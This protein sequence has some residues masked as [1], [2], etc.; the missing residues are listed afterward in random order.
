MGF[1]ALLEL[2]MLSSH[3]PTESPLKKRRKFNVSLPDDA[4]V[5]IPPSTRSSGAKVSMANLPQEYE[6]VRLV[7]D[8]LNPHET[9]DA[10]TP[11]CEWDGVGCSQGDVVT[12]IRWTGRDL[13]GSLHLSHFM[14]TM[15]RFNV[16]RNALTGE[17][18]LLDLPSSL[19]YLCLSENRFVGALD[20]TSLPQKLAELDIY[21]NSFTEG[22]CL[23]RL[24]PALEGLYLSSNNL[25]GSV[26]LTSLPQSMKQLGLRDNLL[27]GEISLSQLPQNLLGLSLRNNDFCGVVDFRRLPFTLRWLDVSDNERITGEIAPSRYLN[28]Q[29]SVANTGVHVVVE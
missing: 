14:Q 19:R 5:Q 7:R 17:I 13:H 9:W 1:L 29:F 6:L 27:S 3:D 4:T 11:A 8:I 25:T 20:L 2:K 12:R 23:T 21:D 28:L 15:K 18:D 10:K 16:G 26:D 22:V 24:S